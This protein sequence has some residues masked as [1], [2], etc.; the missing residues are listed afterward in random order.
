MI[1]DKLPPHSVDIEESILAS[2]LIDSDSIHEA[3]IVPDSFYKPAHVLIYSAM[4]ELQSENKPIDILSVSEHLKLKGDIEAAG[5]VTY[6]SRLID[7]PISPNMEY[8][9][10]ILRKDYDL[11]KLITISADII[12]CSYDNQKKPIEI[13]EAAQKEFHDIG[14]STSGTSNMKDVLNDTISGLEILMENKGRISGIP[15]G[16][17]DLDRHTSGLQKTDF[18]LIGGRPAMGKT[19]FVMNIVKNAII[20]I[21]P[22]L[23]FSLEMSKYQL[24]HRFLSDLADV[25]GMNFR[26]GNFS[27]SEW[28]RI[29][30]ASTRLFD[31]PLHINDD[32]GL[33]AEQI[34]SISSKMVRKNKIKLI[35]IDYIQLIKGWNRDGQGSKAEI[36]RTMKLMAKSLN[37]P[38]ICLSQ[39]NRSLE[40]RKDKRPIMADLREAGAL[41]QDADIISFIYRDEVYEKNSTDK[42]VAEILIRKNR[43]GSIGTVKVGFVPEYTR[44]YNLE[45]DF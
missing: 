41:E 39:L 19:S 26:N 42:G 40:I 27:T 22:T 36:S 17:R 28:K 12:S 8:S 33:S 35:V 14:A 20:N 24:T 44:F 11:R 30:T 4:V 7:C 23:V 37:V 15:T 32:S 21:Y 29:N 6:L 43:Q 2:I 13:L 25:N 38:V 9:C 10:S 5:G 45:R 31:L 3:N 1:P 34:L 16:F 18:I